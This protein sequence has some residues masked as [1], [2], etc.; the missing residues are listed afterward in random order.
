LHC[1]WELSKPPSGYW[2]PPIPN[3]IADHRLTDHYLVTNS[4]AYLARCKHL[5][6]LHLTNYL[7]VAYS[8]THCEQLTNHHLIDHHLTNYLL[9]TNSLAHC[10]HLPHGLTNSL[11]TATPS[12]TPSTPPL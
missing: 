2:L 4:L 11:I 6:N 8:L 5:T 9:V 7:L 1:A 12:A 10:N 3:H